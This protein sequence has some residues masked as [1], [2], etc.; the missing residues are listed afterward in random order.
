[1]KRTNMSNDSSKKE[2][3]EKEQMWK[4]VKS[5]KEYLNND[6]YDMKSLKMDNSEKEESKRK[7]LKNLSRKNRHF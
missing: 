3:S 5:E 7:I 4:K 2:N 1:M 6:N